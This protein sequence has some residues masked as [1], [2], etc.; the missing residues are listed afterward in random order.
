M[1]SF[2]FLKIPPSILWLVFIVVAL[3]V[4]FCSNRISKYVAGISEKTKLGGAFL[5]AFVLSF[6]TSIP[7]VIS[8]ITSSL[9]NN[10][11]LSYGNVIGVNMMTLTMLAVM[12]IIFMKKGLFSKISKTNRKT[13][14]YVFIFNVLLLI[15]LFVD[16][17][18]N[19]KI[20][21][22][23]TKISPVFVFMFLFY[24]FF[25]YHVY[26]TGQ[27]ENDEEAEE[28]GCAQLSLKT[29]LVRFFLYSIALITLSVLI[30]NIT[31]QM[32]LPT[33]EGGYGLG[34][35]V[36]G[37]LFLSL[38]TGLP[39]MTSCVSLAKMGQGNMALGGIIGSHL[40][41]FII[42]FFGDL[43]FAKD[44]TMIELA[45][46]NE[47]FLTIKISIIVG[48]ILNLLLFCNT[49]KKNVK[50]KFIYILPCVIILIIYL[51]FWFCKDAII[52]MF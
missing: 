33:S 8:S 17:I 13:I 45:K 5:G 47:Q 41:N 16:P 29:V 15:S 7:E 46:N 48:M 40:F 10:P 52:G 27:E 2:A 20:N 22:G 19:F 50:N 37:A 35:A 51:A 42:F 38:C 32:A 34:S 24:V 39:E 25:I 44:S 4:V 28:S 36:A 30:A 3:G 18:R 12:D 9:L 23:F 1:I 31:D 26:K 21:L 43:F 14:L 11:T 6:V 49:F